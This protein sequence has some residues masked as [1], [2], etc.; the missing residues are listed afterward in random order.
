MYSILYQKLVLAAIVAT[1]SFTAN[2]ADFT[3]V[4]ASQVSLQRLHISPCGARQWG[5][6]QLI[7]PLPPS[8]HFTI[9]DITPGCYDV[10]FVVAPWNVCVL[11]GADLRR[12]KVWKVTQ[13]TVFGS[14]SGDCSHVADY[15]SVGR[16]P[17]T[18]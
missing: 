17:W 14:Q 9:S 15:A 1:V 8:R 7:E 16:R 11:A 2:A 6:D 5:P 12:H 13:W 4:N 18:W 3:I 10:E